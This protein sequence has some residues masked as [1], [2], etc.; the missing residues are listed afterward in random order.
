[1][2]Q[3]SSVEW[4]EIQL[5]NF[6]DRRQTHYEYDQIIIQAKEMHKAETLEF[7]RTMPKEKGITQEGESYVQ[8]NSE[9][10]Y[11]NTYSKI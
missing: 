6:N 5:R 10:H 8:Y 9:A 1:M 3:L 7:V 11:N 2:A 4:L